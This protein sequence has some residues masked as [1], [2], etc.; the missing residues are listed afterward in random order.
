MKAIL[1]FLL[2]A[3]CVALAACG[4][5]VPQPAHTPRHAKPAE[6]GE[7]LPAER[8][9]FEEPP[10]DVLRKFMFKAY[11]KMDDA[12]GVPVTVTATGKSGKVRVKLYEVK[13]TGCKLIDIPSVAP[14]GKFEC[15]VNL[16]VKMWWDGQREPRE[17]A[18]DNKR[19]DVIQDDRGNWLDCD[20]DA[21][22]NKA[23]CDVR[24]A[25]KRVRGK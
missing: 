3:S 21:Q 6:S 24:A 7:A 8:T 23:F 2:V 1:S 15:T 11:E 22:E 10:E 25:K 12:G 13:K 14:P 4:K 20:H 18:D 5:E 19:I 17:P 9:S 16:Q